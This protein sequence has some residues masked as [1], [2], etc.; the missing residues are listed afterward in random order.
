MA[1]LD[2]QERCK[3]ARITQ[4]GDVWRHRKT[5][6]QVVVTHRVGLYG[7]GL[8]HPSGRKSM[9]LD[10]YLASDYEL[11]FPDPTPEEV[12]TLGTSY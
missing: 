7:I 11:M 10:H 3:Q 2:Y 5:G 4:A 9:K 12:R 1:D 8:S 6:K